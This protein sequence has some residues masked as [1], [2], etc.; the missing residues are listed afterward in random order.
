MRR[1]PIVTLAVVLAGGCCPAAEVPVVRPAPAA[2]AL[3]APA[4]ALVAEPLTSAGGEAWT[5]DTNPSGKFDYPSAIAVAGDAVYVTGYEGV[6]GA[7]RV[8]RRRAADGALVWEHR[9]TPTY[10]GVRD[11]AVAGDDVFLAGDTQVEK[12]AAA[13]GSLVPGFGTGGQVFVGKRGK[14]VVDERIHAIAV[15][16]DAIFL[17]GESHG[18]LWIQKRDRVTGALVGSFATG[19][20][21]LFDPSAGPNGRSLGSNYL[22]SAALAGDGL[23]AAGFQAAGGERGRVQ[24]LRASDGAFDPRFG[25][26]GAIAT[27]PP[28]HVNTASAVVVHGGA[29]Y[30]LVEDWVRGGNSQWYVEQRAASDGARAWSIPLDPSGGA[31]TAGGLAVDAVGVVVVGAV[32][33]DR[34]VIYQVGLDGRGGSKIERDPGPGRDEATAVAVDAAWIYVAG[35]STE[36][37]QDTRWR[38]ERIPRGAAAGPAIAR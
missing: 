19:G 21:W 1:R 17:A 6:G 24:R 35:F 25:T 32:G 23:I 20:M 7:W 29:I 10:W 11:L 15:A 38:I 4:P 3:P 33:T 9:T 13:D 2:A 37:G 26:D 12:R 36:T 27:G 14:D 28:G 18:G 30:L 16:S 31:D 5:I 34:W 22:L 8:E